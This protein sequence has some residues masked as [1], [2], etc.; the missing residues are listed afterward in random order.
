MST[1][2]SQVNLL[3]GL[4]TYFDHFQKQLNGSANTPLNQLRK[5]AFEHLSTLHFPNNKHEEW[6]YTNFVKVLSQDFALQQPSILSKEDL[7]A[8]VP[9]DVDA[10]FL[11]FLNGVY[12]GDLSSVESQKG[13]YVGNFAQGYAQNPTLFTEVFAKYAK[14]EQDA[15]TAL[16]TAFAT[17]GAFIH[18]E[19]N[20]TI[21]KPIFILHLLD[22]TSQKP[23][24]QPRNLVIVGEQAACTIIEDFVSIGEQTHLINQVSE[25]EVGKYARVDHYILQ[26]KAS[27]CYAITTTQVQQHGSSHYANTTITLGGGMVRNNLNI[28][29][30][31]SHSESFMNGLYLLKG[32]DHVDNHTLVDHQQPNCYSNEL[33]KGILDG[34]S[35]GVFNG[36][37]YV[38]QAAQK[39]NAYQ[40][41]KNI[42]LSPQATVN[43]K[44]QLEIWA[45]D[46]KCSHGTTTGALDEEP[47]FYLRSRGISYDQARSLLMHAFAMDVLDRIKV[48]SFRQKVEA[49]LNERLS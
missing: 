5:Q 37:I 16:S 42:L 35:T 36:K 6:K 3:S 33:Y 15:F 41:N 23:L 44:P 48:E 47:L 27:S 32:K 29:L 34:Q 2:I 38:R 1:A 28:V 31:G 22:V 30:D 10:H 7:K 13:L 9:T 45:D 18:V 43:T 40:S 39:T 19:K 21:E 8:W 17:D 46:V 24:V 20:I 14:I 4:E 26:N 12:Q 49:L 25:I 11:V